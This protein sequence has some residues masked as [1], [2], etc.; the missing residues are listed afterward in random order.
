LYKNIKSLTGWGMMKLYKIAFIAAAIETGNAVMNQRMPF[1]I[2]ST[3][4]SASTFLPN[5]Y[6]TLT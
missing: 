4:T 5:N 6:V 1:F 3:L 2:I